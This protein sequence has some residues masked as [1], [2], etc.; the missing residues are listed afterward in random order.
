[1]LL[2]SAVIYD[3]ATCVRVDMHV[4]AYIDINY[5]IFINV[6]VCFS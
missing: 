6:V 4:H 2:G 5:K 1:M 3:Y